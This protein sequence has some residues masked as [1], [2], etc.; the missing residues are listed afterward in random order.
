MVLLRIG[1]GDELIV[2][3]EDLRFGEAMAI[4][5]I[6]QNV[7]DRLGSRLSHDLAFGQQGVF[8]RFPLRLHVVGDEYRQQDR[9]A[10]Q[11]QQ[12]HFSLHA[13]G[14]PQYRFA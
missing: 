12:S 7:A 9:Y 5:R 6:L 4:D 8:G 1:V 14:D 3:I 11:H 13:A 10:R 2:G